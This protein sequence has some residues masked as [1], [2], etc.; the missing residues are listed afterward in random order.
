MEGAVV[1]GAAAE[2]TVVEEYA[3]LPAQGEPAPAKE[4]EPVR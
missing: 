2:E 1:D 4:K 3:S